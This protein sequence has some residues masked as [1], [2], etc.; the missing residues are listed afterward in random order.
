[1]TEK[2]DR[3]KEIM[4]N[5]YLQEAFEAIHQKCLYVMIN[6]PVEMTEE[7]LTVIM[8]A[9]RMLKALDQLEAELENAV[10]EGKLEDFHA[11]QQPYLGDLNGRKP[12]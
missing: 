6:A 7:N 9:K 1:M 8:D 2:A 4:E 10:R 12:N 11:E 3:V 5:K